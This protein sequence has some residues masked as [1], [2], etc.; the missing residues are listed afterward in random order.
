[1]ASLQIQQLL[2]LASPEVFGTTPVGVLAHA[3]LD[4]G[5]YPGVEGIVGTQ[6]DIDLPIQAAGSF[7]EAL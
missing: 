3:P 4:I 5:G 7:N 2:R 1:V 6:Y